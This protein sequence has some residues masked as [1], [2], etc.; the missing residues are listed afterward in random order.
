MHIHRAAGGIAIGLALLLGSARAACPP[1][2]WDEPALERL[3]AAK[4]MLPDAAARAA[5]ADALLADCLA[6][7]R[8]RLRD[9]LAFDALAA[10][11]RAGAL[12]TAQLDAMRPELTHRLSAEDPSGFARPFAALTLAEIA[13]V[14]RLTPFLDG[15]A[16]DDLLRA[17]VA[18][19]R[20]V[21]D[22]RGF[23]PVQGWRHGV[24]HGADLL[25][26]LAL[27]PAFD[28]TALD[29]II[30]AVAAQVA[31]PGEHFYVY[32]ES[33]RLARPVVY[34]A[35][36]GVHDAA[37]WNGWLMALVSPG[38][39]ANW[40]DAVKIRAGLARR[41]NTQAFLQVLYVMVRESGDATLQQ[42]LL[43][44]LVGALKALP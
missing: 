10:W 8:P 25:L 6:D 2:G 12:P 32:G 30:G 29:Q 36:R 37:F 1:A 39:L 42:R 28:R 41:H 22:H 34:A 38:P 43:P 16:R 24:A 33:E 19:E 5:L 13:R 9:A 15:A 20:G 23:D 3:R 7:P 40:D 44:G 4:F 35:R 17:A 31:P 18:Y 21:R 11:M 14:D 27:N 26:Q